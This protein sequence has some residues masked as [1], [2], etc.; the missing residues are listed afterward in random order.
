MGLLATAERLYH[1]YRLGRKRFRT[2]EDYVELM[3]YLAEDFATRVIRPAEYASGMVLDVG[4]SYGGYMEAFEINGAARVVGLDLSPVKF[5]QG[6]VR[7]AVVGDMTLSHFADGSFDLVYSRAVIEHVP[8]Q[9]AFCKECDR[10][11]K[12]GGYACVTA[13][14]W[15]SPNA[16]HPR[17]KPF[18]LLPFP[19]A[20]LLSE[21][22]KGIRIEATDLAGLGLYP[23]TTRKLRRHMVETGFEEAR[24]GDGLLGTDWVARIP[25]L[26]E[27]LIQHVFVVGR[28]VD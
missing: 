21:K 4:C 2:H 16:G 10:V 24:I 3:R 27:V 15:Y 26:N 11:L 20:R 28:R 9:L 8:D 25:I 23:I 17:L 6:N 13:P 19:L 22:T 7:N 12:P 1:L 5:K 18:H 14:P